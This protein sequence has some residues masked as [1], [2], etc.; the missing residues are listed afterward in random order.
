M[1]CRH[2]PRCQTTC[3]ICGGNL[4]DYPNFKHSK[5]AYYCVVFENGATLRNAAPSDQNAID[6]AVASIARSAGLC[7]RHVIRPVELLVADLPSGKYSFLRK[8]TYRE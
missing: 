3:R 6:L 5:L 4:P 7:K 2:N 1:T 8:I